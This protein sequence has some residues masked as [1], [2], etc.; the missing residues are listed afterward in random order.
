MTKAESKALSEASRAVNEIQFDLEDARKRKKAAL[1][2]GDRDGFI[3]AGIEEDMLEVRH[4]E[5]FW[6]HFN[7]AGKVGHRAFNKEPTE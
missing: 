2:A 5:A 7:L 4:T 1:E 3:A 6:L